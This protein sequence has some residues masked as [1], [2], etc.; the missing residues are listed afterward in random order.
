MRSPCKEKKKKPLSSSVLLDWWPTP[1]P[2]PSLGKIGVKHSSRCSPPTPTPPLP[3][4]VA[5]SF[6]L[7][8]KFG[9][10][11]FFPGSCIKVKKITSRLRLSTGSGSEEGAAATEGGG[12]VCFH[13]QVI[14]TVEDGMGSRGGG[15]S[16]WS[17]RANRF[18]SPPLRV[19]SQRGIHRMPCFPHKAARGGGTVE[20]GECGN[21]GNLL[22]KTARALCMLAGLACPPQGNLSAGC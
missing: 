3:P 7:R 9:R 12:G 10:G 17:C 2:T 16:Q 19:C 5:I 18:S 22:L 1:S 8:D 4:S 20:R 15:A 13:P 14:V 6:K 11:S 21:L